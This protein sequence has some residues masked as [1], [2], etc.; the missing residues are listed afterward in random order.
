MAIRNEREI[1]GIQVGKEEVKLSVTADYIVLY[2]ENPKDTTRKQNSSMNLVKLQDTKL[3]HRNL[4]PFHIL[5][6]KDQKDKKNK[7]TRNK[8]T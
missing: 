3:T 1:K 2:I 6:M 7:I 4:L 5:T 8:P